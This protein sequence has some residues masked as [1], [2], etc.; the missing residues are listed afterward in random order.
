MKRLMALALALALVAISVT[1]QAQTAK[2][3]LVQKLLRLQQPNIESLA[4]E[5]AAR[6]ATQIFQAVGNVLQTQV[7]ADKREATGKAIETELKKYVDEATPLL[8][9]RAIKLAPATYGAALE[10][11]FSKAELKRLIAWFESPVNKKYQQF[12][13]EAQSAF[14]QKLVA[15]ATPVLDPKLE[16]LQQRIRGLLGVPAAGAAAS[17]AS[18]PK[19]DVK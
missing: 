19:A 2:K 17:G 18:A 3:D 10:E 15:E 14:I 7:P 12:A 5:L 1:A 11:K 6:P 9:E 13:P 8:R 16:A 4:R